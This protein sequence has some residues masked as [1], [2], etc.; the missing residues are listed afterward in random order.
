M[1]ECAPKWRNKVQ[2]TAASNIGTKAGYNARRWTKWGK[3][4]IS[5]IR[6]TVREVLD[7]ENPLYKDLKEYWKPSAAAL[8]PLS[9][10]VLF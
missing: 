3:S 9:A 1:V 5:T 6:E 10:A 8:L 4:P 7:E 2:V